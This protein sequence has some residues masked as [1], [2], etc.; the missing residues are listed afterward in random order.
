MKILA[1]VAGTND[2]SNA[3]YLADRF[4]E[5]ARQQNATMDVEK[6]RIRDLHI[7]H[8]T[9]E[10]YGTSCDPGKDFWRV[11]DAILGSDGILIATPIW[12]FSV[13]AHLKNLLDHIGTFGLDAETRSKGMFGG[14]PFFFLFTGGAPVPAWKGLMRF[15]TMHVPEA[16]RYF[17]GTVVG[18]DF[19]GK[20]MAG[21]GKFG[22]VVDK[23][24]ETIARIRER[25]RK[26]AAFVER[27]KMTGKLP[28]WHRFVTACY[29]KGQ[30]IMGKL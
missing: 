29:L 23:R 10:C 22:L 16:I 20:C 21:K 5:G 8:F 30:R 9:V 28:P 11:K 25:G 13:P 6:I 4:L 14:T 2:P 1:L 7:A 27:W 15:T 26:F 3:E 24:P 12:N 18:K 19:E 17:G